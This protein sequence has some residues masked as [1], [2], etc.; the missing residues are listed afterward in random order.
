VVASFLAFLFPKPLYTCTHIFQIIFKF[1]PP[2]KRSRCD[3]Q[4]PVHTELAKHTHKPRIGFRVQGSSSGFR[5]SC[6]RIGFRV[7]GSRLG[8]GFR[9]HG[10]FRV[11]VKDFKGNSIL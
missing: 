8:S 2:K 5:V 10:G 9:V 11:L 6:S 1:Q 4:E 7:H 3:Q